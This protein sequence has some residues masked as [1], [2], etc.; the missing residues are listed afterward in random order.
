MPR[1]FAPRAAAASAALVVAIATGPFAPA[2]RAEISPEAARVVARYLEVTGGAAAAAAEQTTY[3]H[4]RVQAFGFTGFV[5]TW[6]ARPDRHFSRTELGPFKL[7]E[8]SEGG[9]SWRTDPTTGRVVSLA[10]RDLLES[11]VATWFEL[12]RWSEP[13]QGGGRVS[14]AGRERDTLGACTVLAIE[15]PGA[16][17]LK[18]RKLWFSDSTGLLVRMEAPHDQSWVTTDFADW[19]RAAGRLRPFVSVTGVSSMPANRMR[20][21]VDS[22]T[23]NVSVAGV[24]FALPDSGGGNAI[25]WLGKPGRATLPFD[26]TARHVWLRASINGGPEQD[27]LFDTG[28]SVTVL[29]STFAATH[30]IA[31]EGRMQ[32]AGAG[33]SGSAAFAKIASLAVRGPDGDGVELHDLRV[34]VLSVNPMFAPYFWRDIAGI[35]GYDFISR[36][37]VTLDY[38]RDVLVLN[39]PKTFHFAGSEAPLPMVMNGVVPALRGTLDGRYEGLFRLDVGSSSTVDLHSPFAKKHGLEKRLR[40]ARTVTGAGF[41][42]HFTSSLGR[43]REMAFGP[44]HWADPMVSISHATEGAFA[45]EEFAGNVGNRILE[46]FRVTLDYDGRRVWLEPGARYRERDSF[47]RA[48]VL[49]VRDGGRV[50]ARSVLAGSPAARAG[51]REGD[52]VTAVDGRAMDDWKLRDLENLFERGENG[53]KVTLAVRRDGGTEALTLTL[54]EMLR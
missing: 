35:V 39:D 12:E 38:D 37:V 52:E 45:S 41:G 4:A 9:A 51:L 47:T 40:D 10:D 36:F 22:V 25:T 26:Y 42:G 24:A 34:A 53:R 33:A 50:L 20:A 1:S 32:A 18:P 48:G 2:A 29:D 21:V 43:A 27:F 3:T 7:S 19:R 31:T 17:E 23:T 54:R 16:A 49:L 11:R 46:R 13:D 28:A 14:V 30:G 8:G 5:E 44:Y 6:S 15:A